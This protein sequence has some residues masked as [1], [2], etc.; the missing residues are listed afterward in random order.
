MRAEI[1]FYSL[2]FLLTVMVFLYLFRAFIRSYSGQ[3]RLERKD[4]SQVGFV[5]DTFQELVSKLKEK[6]RELEVLRKEAED[7]AVAIEGYNENILQ[8]VPSGVISFNDEMRITKI[9][10]AAEKILE[11][12]GET[13]IGRYHTDVLNKPITDLLHN[14]KVIERGEISCIT[15]SGKKIWLGFTLSPLKDRKGMTIGQILVF[16][17]LTHLK[18]FEAQM[19]LR[20][21]LSSL[22]EISAGI[23]HELRNPMGVIAGYTK[24]LTKKAD[25]SLKPTVDAISKEIVVMDRIISDFLSFTRPVELTI[26]DIDLKAIIENCTATI[27]DKRIDIKLRLDMNALPVIKGDEVLLRQA[28]TNLIQNAVEAMPQGGELTVKASPSA[29]SS[30]DFLDVSI[31][32][33]GHGIAENIKD[34]IFL[35]FFTTKES[36]TGLGLAIVH[37]IVVAHGGNISVDSS[38]KGTT[39]R[40]KFPLVI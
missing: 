1:I 8:S 30:G 28:F 15:P 21:K 40:I 19:E 35:P 16:T 25:N 18:A 29:G 14:R 3:K 9:N 34:K 6:E 31:F 27:V 4:V 32:D 10:Q 26:S 12:K 38:D 2:I 24:L 22:G 17:D 39:F 37:N 7:R 36:G 20:A 33:T 5:V 11:V 23:A 13:T